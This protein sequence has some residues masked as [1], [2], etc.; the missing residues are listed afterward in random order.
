[1]GRVSQVTDLGDHAGKGEI[2]EIL[3]D[4][5]RLR[6]VVIEAWRNSAV[7]LVKEERRRLREEIHALC[8]TLMA[9]TSE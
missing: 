3:A 8:E 4:V 1:M 5:R 2:D 9:L 6:G 7:M